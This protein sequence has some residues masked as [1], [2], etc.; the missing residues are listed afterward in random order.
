M[1]IILLLFFVNTLCFGQ[2]ISYQTITVEP[3]KSLQNY[4]HFKRLV[5]NSSA[6][7]ADFIEDFEF[8]WGYCYTLKVKEEKIMPLSDGTRFNYYLCKI[9]SKKK[10]ADSFRFGM[11]VDPLK[12]YNKIVAGSLH[13]NEE[14]NY[15]IKQ[16]NDS[17]YLY[18]D[19]V[20]IIVPFFH[21]ESFKTKLSQ[22]SGFKAIFSIINRNRI[23]LE[24]FK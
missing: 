17:T 22:E 24:N 9:V 15:S 1:K 12:Y 13:E 16:L 21:Q 8:Q 14:D 23:R 10:V 7:E 20:E 3:Y 11:F 4:E 19:E 5:L 2:N 6:I 18:M